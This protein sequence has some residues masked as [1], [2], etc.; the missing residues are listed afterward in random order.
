[1]KVLLYSV[2]VILFDQ[3]TKLLIKGFKIPFLNIN[4][5]GVKINSSIK[6]LDDFIQITHVENYGLAFGIDF[7]RDAKVALTVFTI[8]A[9]ILILYYLYIS[10][11]KDFKVRFAIALILGGACGNLIDRIFY[12]V[13]YGYAPLF[14]GRVV[15]FIHIDFF[16]YNLFGKTYESLPI[17]NFADV[18][19]LIGIIILFYLSFKTNIDP[20]DE[21]D[22]V[23]IKH[24]TAS[25]NSQE[26]DQTS[27]PNQD[28][29]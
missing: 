1:M 28:K 29:D 22:E 5:R 11:F 27:N 15:D 24:E 23:S 6:I 14:H 2:V 8:I 26:N 13:L 25:K 20:T 4:H 17:F 21:P 7:G 19:V 16:D 3:I 9:T 18:S 12:G 10:R